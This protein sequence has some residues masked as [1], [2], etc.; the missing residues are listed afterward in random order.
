MELRGFKSHLSPISV[1]PLI[2]RIRSNLQIRPSSK[3]NK[4]PIT[5]NTISLCEERVSDGWKKVQPARCCERRRW[6]V[7]KSRFTPQIRIMQDACT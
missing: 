6:R 5:D 4:N 3:L 2:R 7:L 1:F